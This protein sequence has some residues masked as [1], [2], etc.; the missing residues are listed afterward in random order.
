MA[1]PSG[2]ECGQDEEGAGGGSAASET[3]GIGRLPDCTAPTIHEALA[4]HP[5][6]PTRTLPATRFARGGRGWRRRRIDTKG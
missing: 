3:M 1:A 2:T 4:L 6:P 5:A